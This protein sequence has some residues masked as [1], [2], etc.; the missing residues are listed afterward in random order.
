MKTAPPNKIPLRVGGRAELAPQTPETHPRITRTLS[1]RSIP[2]MLALAL[3]LG[4]IH[5]SAADLELEFGPAL[6]EKAIETPAMIETGFGRR[7]T[8][9]GSPSYDSPLYEGLWP[10][11]IAAFRHHELRADFLE[12]KFQSPVKIKIDTFLLA[13]ADTHPIRDSLWPMT[14]E[15]FQR[16]D[17]PKYEDTEI[18]TFC[19]AAND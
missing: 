4:S 5:A 7:F 10:M 13:S 9:E 19:I 14:L 2:V 8:I 15:A 16:L 6:F 18:F 3:A 1:M 11:T 12:K 17:A